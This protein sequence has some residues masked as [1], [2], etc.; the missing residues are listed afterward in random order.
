MLSPHAIQVQN[1]HQLQH[2]SSYL[3]VKFRTLLHHRYHQHSTLWGCLVILQGRKFKHTSCQLR[4]QVSTLWNHLLKLHCWASLPVLM[5]HILLL[6]KCLLQPPPMNP[7]YLTFHS[8]VT[9]YW[10]RSVYLFL[11]THDP[12]QLMQFHFHFAQPVAMALNMGV[13]VGSSPPVCSQV[14]VRWWSQ[15]FC[16]LGLTSNIRTT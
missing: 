10:E 8:I 1:L 5:P 6:G 12:S 7:F 2:C 9:N 14:G 3:C 4:T 11:S 16:I 15:F 13:A